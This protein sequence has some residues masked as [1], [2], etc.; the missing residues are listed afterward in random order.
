MTLDHTVPEFYILGGVGVKDDCW[1]YHEKGH[2]S[3]CTLM[4][5]HLGCISKVM[6]KQTSLYLVILL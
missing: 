5:L 6:E 3:A 2:C 1:D 4:D